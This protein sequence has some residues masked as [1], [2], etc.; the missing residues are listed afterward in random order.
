MVNNLLQC[1]CSSTILKW[2]F[3][4]NLC[5]LS[6]WFTEKVMMLKSL[7]DKPLSFTPGNVNYLPGF[8][9]PSPHSWERGISEW[10]VK[11]RCVPHWPQEKESLYILVASS[12]PGVTGVSGSCAGDIP[13][14]ESSSQGPLGGICWNLPIPFCCC[15]ILPPTPPL[16]VIEYLIGHPYEKTLCNPKTLTALLWGEYRIW[17]IQVNW[18]VL[19]TL[20]FATSLIFAGSK[21][22]LIHLLYNSK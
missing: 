12:H 10:Q 21:I 20:I 16:E 7:C 4:V 8:C 9:N 22:I 3:P 18:L 5:L 15:W 17:F 19:P 11:V 14:L 13:G 6:P 2:N 1:S